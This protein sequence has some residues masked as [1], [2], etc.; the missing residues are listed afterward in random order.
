MSDEWDDLA[1][2]GSDEWGALKDWEQQFMMKY[3]LVGWLERE[4]GNDSSKDD[5]VVDQPVVKE[6]ES[7]GP[8]QKGDT[9][10]DLLEDSHIQDADQA[11][12]SQPDENQPVQETAQVEDGQEQSYDQ[13]EGSQ[14]EDQEVEDGQEQTNK[15]WKMVI[16]QRAVNMK[17][18][19]M[20]MTKRKQ[21]IRIK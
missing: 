10:D 18:K 14:H 2:L 8:D 21:M 5:V 4:P 1:D 13:T 6:V 11:D 16:K 17:I 15:R 9:I 19:N 3:K 12:E 20:V 7:I